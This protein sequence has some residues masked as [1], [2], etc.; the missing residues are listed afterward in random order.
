MIVAKD[1]DARERLQR[2]LE[3]RAAEEFPERRGASSPLEL[4][5]PVGW[6]MQYRVSG[7]DKNEVRE[8][9]LRL[10]QVVAT[11]PMRRRINFDWIEPA[12]QMRI[13]IDQDQARL[14]GMSSADDRGTC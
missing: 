8:I 1:V 10:A 11:N 7:P 6:P 13:R 14:L 9:A 12:R 3:K 2:K 4:G 5:P